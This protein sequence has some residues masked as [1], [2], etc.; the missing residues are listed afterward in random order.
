[1]KLTVDQTLRRAVKEHSE[2]N[3]VNAERLY[4]AILESYPQHPDANHNLGVLAVTLNKSAD[5]LLSL[6]WF[7]QGHRQH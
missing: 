4:R 6:R 1:M 5:A 3:L 7:C 2:G